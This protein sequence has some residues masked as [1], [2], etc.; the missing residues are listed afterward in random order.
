MTVWA[1]DGGLELV[2]HAAGTPRGWH[3]T[4]AEPAAAVRCLRAA[5]L[6]RPAP[7][8]VVLR[9]AGADLAAGL[10][11]ALAGEF[12]VSEP[13]GP[14]LHEAAAAGAAE[15]LH[16]KADPPVDLRTGPL[17]DPDPLRAVRGPLRLL[18]A[19]L[20]LSLLAV[21]AA[22]LWRAAALGALAGDRQLAAEETFRELFP[23]QRAPAAVRRRLESERAAAAGVRG[24]AGGA[25]A[26]EDA[27]ATLAAVLAALPPADALP[28]R[29]DD[30][31]VEGRRADVS[32]AV[33]ELVQVA[34]AA[35]R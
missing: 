35:S 27:A 34:A 25:P 33:R 12:D 9:V 6:T 5:A 21:A 3:R 7:P 28:L 11:D 2:E 26:A 13:E 24:A 31:R 14:G 15:I 29:V 23:G 10:R 20:A 1:S 19:S 22:L 18:G 8:R 4:A 32:G 16:G 17:A 30:V